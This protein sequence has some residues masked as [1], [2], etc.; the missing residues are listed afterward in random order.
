[1]RRL[2]S[3]AI[4]ALCGC[5]E[6]HARA[7]GL[8][9]PACSLALEIP[10]SRRPIARHDA[11]RSA[12]R[13]LDRSGIYHLTLRFIGDIDDVLAREIA[14]MLG[15][16]RRGAFELRLDGLSS[17]GGRKPRAVVATRRAAPAA[18]GTAGG[19]RAAAAA[20]RARARRPQIH[21]A[22]HAGA[23]ARFVEPA[24]RRLS[25]G[26]RAISARPRSR[27]RASCCSPRAPRSAA[28]PMWSKRPIRSRRRSC[29][30]LRAL[31]DFLMRSRS[32][33]QHARL[34]IEHRGRK[35]VAVGHDLT[36]QRQRRRP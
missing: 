34:H 11:G 18:D 12:G 22:C 27:S 5:C 6:S 17:F 16:V 24:G 23:A 7:A 31:S 10:A 21:A 2:R 9:C 8:P 14:G 36:H 3:H 30:G 19:A 4:A 32:R 26:A 15:R 35:S 28:A 29:G 33:A 20:A 25:G 13:A 1:M